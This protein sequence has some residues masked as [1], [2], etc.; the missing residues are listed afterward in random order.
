MLNMSSIMGVISEASAAARHPEKPLGLT[1]GIMLAYKAS[2]TAV[3]Q[4]APHRRHN[5]LTPL[6][7]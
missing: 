6:L 7:S 2:K 1:D 4:S 5:G 3:T